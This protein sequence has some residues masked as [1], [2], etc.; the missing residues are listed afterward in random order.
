M[1]SRAISD[2]CMYLNTSRPLCRQTSSS[3][4]AAITLR[5]SSAKSV[6][7]SAYKY[8][9]G[10]AVLVAALLTVSTIPA[11]EAFTYAAAN[12]KSHHL[13]VGYRAPGDRLVLKEYIIKNS[14]WMKVQSIQKTFNVSR[15]E[16]ITMVE[17][18]DQKTNG[19]GAYASILN[20]GPG[21]SNVT[22]KFKSQRGHGINFI[23]NIYAR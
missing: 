7:M 15:Y 2:Y 18:L 5:F 1:I 22:M 21:H 10:L 3:F 23:V 8:I 16:H 9:I 14:S 6:K 13:I 17:A 12:N 20:G 4:P 19:N 11:S